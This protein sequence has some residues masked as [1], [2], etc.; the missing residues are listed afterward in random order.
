M[1]LIHLV[2]KEVIFDIIVNYISNKNKQE[3][4]GKYL[5]VFGNK[6]LAVDNSTGNAWTEDFTN[7]KD[8][9]NWLNDRSETNEY[10]ET[11]VKNA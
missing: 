4:I 5:T 8:A 7:L 10:Q 2:T 6:Y 1:L 3:Q 11:M 9:I